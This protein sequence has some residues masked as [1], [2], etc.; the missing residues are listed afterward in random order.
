MAALG[1]DT[2]GEA[3]N[4]DENGNPVYLGVPS[5]ES[6]D[7]IRNFS[8]LAAPYTGMNGV[9][10]PSVLISH[11]EVEFYIAEAIL[12]GYVSGDASGHYEKGIQSACEWWGVQETDIAAHLAKEEVKLSSDNE[13]ALKQVWKEEYINFYYQGYDGWI[14]YRR[15]GY[16]EFKVGSAMLTD[17]IMKRMVYPPLIKAINQNNYEQAVSEFL[18]KGDTMLSGS[19]WSE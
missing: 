4:I 1:V 16:P 12:Q 18:D 3:V 2:K 19:W 7:I 17:E 8:G 13:I 15:V 14:N 5:G 11:S 6:P 9:R 10:A